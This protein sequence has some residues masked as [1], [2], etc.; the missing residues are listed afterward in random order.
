MGPA[1]R[2]VFYALGLGSGLRR[3]E[4]GALTPESFS[5]D[6]DPP[7]IT[8]AGQWTK[9]RRVAILPLRQDLATELREW[10]ADKP[11]GKQ[12]F[13]TRGKK[14]VMLHADLRAAGIEPVVD[15]LTIDLHSL[16][17]TH[18]TMLA[19]AGIG[20]VTAQKFARHSDPK[21]TANVYTSLNLADLQKA[22]ESLPP[23][24]SKRGE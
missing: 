24:G 11:P 13:P 3:S 22:V 6:A 23:T 20:L 4:L 10:L 5:L 15:G 19:R 16:R 17:V 8:V 1:D 18:I 21:L 12:L 9:N 7:T 14:K 2:R